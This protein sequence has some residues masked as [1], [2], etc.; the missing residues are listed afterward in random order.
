MLED[1]RDESQSHPNV[2]RREARYKIHDR[3]RQRQLEW[4]GALK[5]TQDMGKGLHKVFLTIVK[6]IQKQLPP[7]GESGSEGSHF[8]PGP[9]NFS[10]VAK[11]SD[12]IKKPWLKATM[13]EIKNLINNQTFLVQDPGKYEPVTPYMDVYKAQIQSDGSIDKLKFENFG[14]RRFVE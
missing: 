2:N 5:A 1:I 9:K 12:D 7:L 13:K 10:E 3:I 8:I 11:L 14:Q 6:E 4:K